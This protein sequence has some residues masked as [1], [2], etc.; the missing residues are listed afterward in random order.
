MGTLESA[1]SEL[2]VA[3]PDEGINSF[4][5]F[6]RLPTE[7]RLRIWGNAIEALL[8]SIISLAPVQTRMLVM[9][10]PIRYA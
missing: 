3:S 2:S 6:P 4:Q 8:G 5:P 9:D 1:I 7:I 10:I